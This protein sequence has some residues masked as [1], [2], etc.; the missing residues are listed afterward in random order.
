MTDLTILLCLKGR[1]NYTRRWL[2][3]LV[4]ENC[5]FQIFIAD[6]DKNKE[7]T[8]ELLKN[9][10]YENLDI[11]YREYPEDTDI[12]SFIQKFGSA[13]N[14]IK[15]KYLICAD[16]DDF[17]LIDNLKAALKHFKKNNKSIETL[18]LQHYRF[19]INNNEKGIDGKMYLHGGNIT[20]QKLKSFDYEHFSNLN[21]FCRLKT[22]IKEFPSDYFFY[23]IH[24][25]SNFK[26]NI[27]ITC[28]YPMN[29]IFFWERHLTYVIAIQGK[30]NSDIT[31]KP[32]LARQEAT[33]S[34]AASLVKKERLSKLRFSKSWK[35]N[36]PNFVEGIFKIFNQFKNISFFKFK[37]LFN[38]YYNYDLSK[39]IF[40][41]FIGSILRKSKTAYNF[42]SKL[43]IKLSKKSRIKLDKNQILEED[44]TLKSLVTFLK[45]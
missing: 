43:L 6:G 16:N 18:A 17:L 39:R 15:T 35:I 27:E 23:A 22:A 34:V 29:Y 19:S 42:F 30:I 4:Y 20:F 33:S 36:Y 40:F 14:S 32:F 10:I 24:K 31:L 45:S 41:G 7:F 28:S 37:F 13:V 21:T 8:K 26:K 38:F 25:T 44:K 12:Q 1:K 9:P 11:I 5:P 2:N 3:W